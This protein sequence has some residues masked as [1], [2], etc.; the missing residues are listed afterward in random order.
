VVV[1]DDGLATGVTAR[2]ALQALR[3]TGVPLHP[4]HTLITWL[5][6][7]LLLSLLVLPS[8]LLLFRQ[9]GCGGR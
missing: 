2:A 7:L 4:N 1:I 6:L 3:A 8:L 9:N 5:L